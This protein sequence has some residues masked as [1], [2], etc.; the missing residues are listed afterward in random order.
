MAV[1]GIESLAD[2]TAKLLKIHTIIELI[3]SLQWGSLCQFAKSNKH[4]HSRNE[5][6]V[7]IWIRWME[8]LRIEE[9]KL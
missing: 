5:K 6:R 4:T 8:Q 7:G 1:G 2:T 9:N 3:S